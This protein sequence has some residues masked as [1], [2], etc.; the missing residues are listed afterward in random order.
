M[1]RIKEELKSIQEKFSKREVELGK[2]E[3]NKQKVELKYSEMTNFQKLKYN[4]G[5]L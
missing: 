3:A 4:R 2:L 1:K 5:L